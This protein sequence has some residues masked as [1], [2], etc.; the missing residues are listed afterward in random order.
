MRS[1]WW[2]YEK[3]MEELWKL[4]IRII[5]HNGAGGFTTIQIM[6][7]KMLFE[8][9]FSHT[10]ESYHFHSLTFDCMLL[11]GALGANI[12]KISSSSIPAFGFQHYLANIWLSL[13][14]NRVLA[15][16]SIISCGISIQLQ[17][18]NSVAKTDTVNI[19]LNGDGWKWMMTEWMKTG[20]ERAF[21]GRMWW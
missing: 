17:N 6:C 10:L 4:S 5:T 2:N 18:Q 15:V 13:Q 8:I 20:H 16:E 9:N 11:V 1:L 12:F 14:S 21:I 3:V 7:F 19:W